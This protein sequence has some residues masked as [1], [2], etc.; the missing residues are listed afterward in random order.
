MSLIIHKKYQVHL[1]KIKLEELHC[2]IKNTKSLSIKETR[3]AMN[4]IS[5]CDI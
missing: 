2:S 5:T 4:I 1:D 3:Q